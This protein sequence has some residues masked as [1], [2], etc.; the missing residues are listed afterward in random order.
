MQNPRFL[1]AQFWPFLARSFSEIHQD[2]WAALLTN[3]MTL[4]H[5]C[6]HDY[7]SDIQKKKRSFFFQFPEKFQIDV[8]VDCH[9]AE[10]YSTVTLK[11]S[12]DTNQLI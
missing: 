2:F 10:Q 4:R 8:L 12:R 1:L 9:P 11:Q 7:A 6:N 3:Q 5:T